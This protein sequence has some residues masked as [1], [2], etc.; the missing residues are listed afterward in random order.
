MPRNT[1]RNLPEVLQTG[2]TRAAVS[3]E[4]VSGTD[5]YPIKKAPAYKVFEVTSG[6]TTFAENV[7]YDLIE[8]SDGDYVSI[9]W[10]IGGN[11]P[12]NGDLFR[13]DQVYDSVLSRYA[14]A[15]DDEMQTLSDDIEEIVYIRHV[16]EGPNSGDITKASGDELDRLG[17][18]YGPLG[19]RQQRSDSS[20]RAYLKS[21]ASSFEGRGSRS[22]LKFAIAAAVNGDV[23]DVEI[24]EDVENLSY[25]IRISNLQ[26]GVLSSVINDLAELAD[27]SGVELEAAVILTEGDNIVLSGTSSSTTTDVGLGGGTLT[28]DGN[29]TLGDI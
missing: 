12:N 9:D 11:S 3:Y 6:G 5:V 27:P 8:N 26:G 20:Y 17:A 15:H 23:E 19:D 7:D 13:I 10:S 18:I 29:S 16:G 2:R 22:G 4:Y 1:I 25:T 28:L 14:A 24:V 21:I